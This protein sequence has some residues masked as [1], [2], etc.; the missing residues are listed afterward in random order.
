[1]VMELL[2]LS[3]EQAPDPEDGVRRTRHLIVRNTLPQLRSTCLVTIMQLLR[4][5]AEWR[6]SESVV[7]IRVG[8]IES[9]WLLLPLDTEQN[10]A[11]LLS[12][13]ITCAWVSEAREINPELVTNALSRC[14][15]YPSIAHGGATRYGL[16]A[17]SN[18]FRIDSPWFELLEQ[19]LP[20]G[21]FY[22]IQP[23]ALAP[24]AD[25]LQ[26]LP[27]EY[28]DDLILANSEEWV[29][30]YVRNELGQSLDGQAVYKNSFDR[31]VHVAK[32]SLKAYS[33]SPL[34]VGFDFARAPAAVVCQVDA[35]G[36]MLVL[37]EAARENMGV[38]KFTNEVLMP[39]LASERFHRCPCFIIGDPSGAQ[40]SQ[41]GEESVFDALRRIGFNA[42]PAVT[43]R[44]EPRIRAVEKFLLQRRSNGA[45]MVIDPSC[46]QLIEA[47]LWKYR[48]KIRKDGMLEN[49]P[50]KIRPWADLS[51]ALQY[52]A[53]GTARSTMARAMA[54]IRNSNTVV[55]ARMP[56]GAWT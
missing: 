27:P 3:C 21:W 12:L 29:D 26:Y 50:D 4:P 31:E 1:M 35:T 19:K 17:E 54:S 51:D 14:G 11:R 9:D 5:I 55:P 16:I 46:V 48:Y 22:L 56:T 24:E 40:R 38:E 53:L 43:N 33:G 15:R 42:Y 25:W 28:Y 44:I 32:N 13:E 7:R 34:I 52:A 30:Q 49:I 47:F 10:I 41:I 37:A 8:D 18:S 20:E 6:P 23:S 45:A 36:R 39:L 2:R